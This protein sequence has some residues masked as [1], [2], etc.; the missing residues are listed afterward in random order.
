VEVADR[1]NRAEEVRAV[2]RHAQSLVALGDD[3]VCGVRS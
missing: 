2:T 1:R 3:D